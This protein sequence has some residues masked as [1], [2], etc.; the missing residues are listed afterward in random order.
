MSASQKGHDDETSDEDSNDDSDDDPMTGG[1]E[2][3]M[4]MS[5]VQARATRRDRRRLKV[6]QETLQ[7]EVLVA[8]RLILERNKKTGEVIDESVLLKELGINSCLA[9]RTPTCQWKPSVDEIA[10]QARIKELN[11]EIERV[12]G[13]PDQPVWY[14]TLA[15]SAQLGGGTAYDRQDLLDELVYEVHEIERRIHLNHIDQELHDCY[16]TRNEYVEVKYLHGYSSVLWT[17]NARKALNARQER[18]IAMNIS[19]EIVD[20]ILD[21]MLEGWYFGER[22]SNYHMIGYV[23]S[24][25]RDEGGGG[26]MRSGQ[27]QVQA[28]GLSVAKAKQ[29]YENQLKG[30]VS[31]E[32]MRGELEEKLMPIEKKKR[33]RAEDR[34]VA[35]EG[36]DY[37]HRLNETEQTLKFGLFILTF[38]YFRAMAFVKREQRSWGGDDDVV[39]GK[40]G[41]GR[42]GGG[43]KKDMTEERRKMLDEEHKLQIR[44]KKMNLILGRARE[45]EARKRDREANERKEA[46]HKLQE[47]VRRQ[48]REKEAIHH[49]QRLYRGHLGRK[50]ASRWAM[51]RAEM[52]AINALLNAAATCLQRVWRGWLGRKEAKETRAEMAYFIALMRAQ[53]AEQDEE[54]YW[55]TH[56]WQRVKKQARGFINEKFRA[57]HAYKTMGGKAFGEDR[58]ADDDE[59]DED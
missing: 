31:F 20:D 43:G 16:Q 21:Y 18:L 10:C 15:L 8:R 59:E 42:G 27:E 24:V 45:G 32:S 23:P 52:T 50:A 44:Q 36:T 51:K 34:R 39:N 19:R 54:E 30:I 37:H 9:C 41:G 2:E 14:S 46:I 22:E 47:I 33:Q 48:R 58:F 49:I 12:R 1:K 38:M 5:K 26:M 6:K 13:D 55:E 25:K 28:V 56:Q 29:R 40:G 11:S 53:E 4:T 3:M 35:K 57:E 17:N 7:Q